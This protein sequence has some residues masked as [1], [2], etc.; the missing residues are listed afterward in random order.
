MDKY[1]ELRIDV[2][3]E[4]EEKLNNSIPGLN[5]THF[6]KY[7]DLLNSIFQWKVKYFV[8]IFGLLTIC[9]QLK[10]LGVF[11]YISQVPVISKFLNSTISQFP[12][13]FLN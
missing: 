1:G 6:K 13:Q 5:M 8:H 3:K 2:L 4:I 11:I 12:V 10:Y 7:G 9:L